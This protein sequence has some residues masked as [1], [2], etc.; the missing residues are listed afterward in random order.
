MI[1]SDYSLLIIIGVAIALFV[2]SEIEY[3]NKK[4]RKNEQEK[5]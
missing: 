2:G 4:E 5:A 1:A 3:R